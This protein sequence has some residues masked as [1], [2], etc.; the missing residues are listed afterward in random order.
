MKEYTEGSGNV[1]RDMGC[2]NP[3]ER[4]AKAELAFIIN[5]IMAERGLSREETGRLLGVDQRGMSALKKG[6]LSE[7]SMEDLFLFLGALDQRIDITIR[8]K[9]ENVSEKPIHVSY[10][11]GPPCL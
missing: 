4:M 9:S 11:E 7:F 2:E 1:F 3:G 5:R 6:R 10:S 8:N